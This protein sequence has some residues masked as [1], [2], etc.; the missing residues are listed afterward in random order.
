MAQYDPPASTR[1][2]LEELLNGLAATPVEHA[3]ERRRMA[4]E[5]G[6]ILE[7]SDLG[8][9]AEMVRLRLA[10]VLE[11]GSPEE[12]KQA[13]EILHGIRERC[14]PWQHPEAFAGASFLLGYIYRTFKEDAE[15]NMNRA[16]A[17]CYEDALRVYTRDADAEMWACTNNNLGM[18]YLILGE[19]GYGRALEAAVQRFQNALTVHTEQAN[20]ASWEMTQR[21]LARALEAQRKAGGGIGV[22]GDHASSLEQKISA[23][24]QQ[25][26]RGA[27]REANP[28]EWARCHHNLGEYIRMRGTG[29]AAKN[30]LRAIAHFESALEV[31]AQD[32]HPRDWA[33]AMSALGAALCLD[34]ENENPADLERGI[35]CLQLALQVRT[36]EQDPRGWGRVS[37]NLAA[38]LLSSIEGREEAGTLAAAELHLA[39]AGEVLT[40]ESAPDLWAMLQVSRARAAVRHH[41]VNATREED[42][43]ATLGAALA[44]FGA[45][46]GPGFQLLALRHLSELHERLARG[47]AASVH[48]LELLNCRRA[49]LQVSLAADLPIPTFLARV[50]LANAIGDLALRPHPDYGRETPAMCELLD[51]GIAALTTALPAPPI[52]LPD[53]HKALFQQNL[54]HLHFYYPGRTELHMAAA[55]ACYETAFAMEGLVDHPKEWTDAA[56]H[57]AEIA[58]WSWQ[59]AGSVQPARRALALLERGLENPPP[60]LSARDLARF[61]TALADVLIVAA[62][63]MGDRPGRRA[64]ALYRLALRT[65]RREPE[66]SAWRPVMSALGRAYLDLTAG[67]R[68]WHIE[69]AIFYFETVL[70]NCVEPDHVV[71]Y[72]LS[73]A[74]HLRG[75][76][77]RRENL[78]RAIEIGRKVV[79]RQD[80]DVLSLA[81][82]LDQLASNYRE[83]IAGDHAENYEQALELYR[84]AR[85][86]LD[87]QL[88]RLEWARLHH[89]EGAAWM[90]RVAGAKW[91][92]T[93]RAIELF[94]VALS[95]RTTEA[96]PRYWAMTALNLGNTILERAVGDPRENLHQAIGH[97]KGA[98]A[99]LT[100]ESDRDNWI[101]AEMGLG[102]AWMKLARYHES[103]AREK[104]LQH[105]RAALDCARETNPRLAAMVACNLAALARTT[106]ERRSSRQEL[107]HSLAQVQTLDDPALEGRLWEAIGSHHFFE[108][109]WAN[110]MRCFDR[111]IAIGRSS[112]LASYTEHGRRLHAG[113]TSDLYARSAMCLI[114]TG[115][116]D[117][118][119]ER[120]DEG[121]ARVL[122]ER[123]NGFAIVPAGVDPTAG[124]AYTHAMAACYHLEH[125]L[126]T[127]SPGAANR[128]QLG[129]ELSKAR[130]TLEEAVEGIRKQVPEFWRDT[131]PVM[132]LLARSGPGW[133]VVAPL[134][135]PVGA[136]VFVVPAGAKSIKP[137]HVLELPAFTTAAQHHLMY[138]TETEPGW[139]QGYAVARPDPQKWRT[140]AEDVMRRLW[141]QLLGPVCDR[142]QE[143]Q[144][145]PQSPILLLPQAGLGALPLHA[146]WRP[147]G[148]ERRTLLDDYLVRTAPAL[149]VLG[150]DNGVTMPQEHR[151]VLV[152]D[153]TK[154]LAF[155]SAEVRTISRLARDDVELLPPEEATPERV[156]SASS[157]AHY[158]H[159]AGH[160]FHNWE[161]PLRS[162]MM[163]AEGRVL[164]AEE[165][166]RGRL[167]LERCQLVVLA[168]CES[169]LSD[170]DDAPDEF[171]GLSYTFL[172]AGAKR[173]LAS[174]WLVNDLASL[175]LMERYYEALFRGQTSVVALRDAQRWLRAV[176]SRELTERFRK[177]R[178][179]PETGLALTRAEV[180]S[181]W[182]HFFSRPP[183]SRPYESVID[184]AAFYVA[185]GE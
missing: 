163:L 75:L 70:A 161:E 34:G 121:K 3:D 118:A 38:A 184:W 65:L 16:A 139:F 101:G 128:E 83:R 124:A 109:D 150:R 9:L 52:P 148:D 140:V 41:E 155:A 84:E 21:N 130:R 105:F 24:E 23:L 64:V 158:I 131:V 116:F 137:H 111:A 179:M 40:P 35:S 59:F 50:A 47:D 60:Q 159:F 86:L 113:R 172:Q 69:R 87:P 91:Q 45:S 153:A 138:G 123:L 39:S 168:A 102:A 141:E 85:E 126:A 90:G 71:L 12:V 114:R 133:A 115:R 20:P 98:A 157:R 72:N 107:E 160:A 31:F 162:G 58:E 169:G 165:I 99:I 79:S 103:G 32:T 76:G 146:A 178:A 82:S 110:A 106:E 80:V 17:R 117:E 14:S 51:E 68:T 29:D 129:E 164:S 100:K 149:R 154:T 176:T 49:S 15:Y 7:G 48:R 127:L 175:L 147:V 54:G 143:L 66:V 73:R 53:S 10:Q 46:L 92:N 174:L 63:R 145:P 182:R 28:E 122:S 18:A 96:S 61:R 181:L 78:E 166:S 183:T 4:G 81:Q 170:V 62:E 171:V 120:L 132:E 173:V 33:L 93:E 74:Y 67:N 89:N 42:I 94:T 151:I 119:F 125:G 156:I 6:D 25:L 180:S 37:A 108:Q 104:S 97:L 11:P 167:K 30:R 57:L 112:L 185:G 22:A 26:S 36:R 13:F 95:V 19:A 27:W 142:L 2:R 88:H 135:T 8:A 56:C 136:I 152:P 77:S 144:I 177:A 55:G 5:I 43:L 134:V 44:E 1:V